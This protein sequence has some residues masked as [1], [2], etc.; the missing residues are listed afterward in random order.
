MRK[1]GTAIAAAILSVAFASSALAQHHGG[2]GGFHGGRG[3]FHGGYH[4]F[5]GGVFVD[6][7]FWDYP[8]LYGYPYPYS[9]YPYP[10]AGPSVYPPPAPPVAAAPPQNVWYYCPS[11]HGYYPYVATCSVA[12]QQV[13]ATPPQ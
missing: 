11:S 12:W 4:G 6:P 3:G 9:A 5:F 13:P 10:Y 7:F 1:F 8:Y 2:H